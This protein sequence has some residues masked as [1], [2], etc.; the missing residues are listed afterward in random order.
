MTWGK[1]NTHWIKFREVEPLPETGCSMCF[2]TDKLLAGSGDATYILQHHS[3]DFKCGCQLYPARVR[4]THHDLCVTCETHKAMME[5]VLKLY[6]EFSQRMV[7]SRAYARPYPAYGVE[8]SRSREGV[9]TIT[10]LDSKCQGKKSYE[11][12]L[13]KPPNSD[14]SPRETTID[15]SW[16][17]LSSATAWKDKCVHRQGVNCRESDRAAVVAPDWLIDTQQNCMVRGNLSMEYVALSYRWGSSVWPRVSLDKIIE[18]Q[19]PGSLSDSPI[20]QLPI[21][22][23][24]IHVVKNIKERYLWVDAACIIH[25]DRDHLLHQ[26]QDMGAI[27]ASAKL[28]IISTDGDAMAGLPGLQH[29]SPPRKLEGIFPWTDNREIFVRDLPST[30]CIFV[31]EYYKRGWTLQEYVL[32]HRRL[33]FGR[34]QIHWTCNCGTWHEDLPKLRSPLDDANE[35][36][37]HSSKILRR[38]PDLSVLGNVLRSYNNLGLTYP[39][40]ALPA[41]AG[42]LKLFSPSFEGGFLFGMPVM[43]FEAA[44]LWGTRFWYYNA[45]GMTYRGLTRRQ[46]SS[47]TPGLMPNAELPSWSWVGWKSD[48][49]SILRDEEDYQVVTYPNQPQEAL[50]RIEKWTTIPTVHWFCQDTP[51]PGGDRERIRSSWSAPY[52]EPLR[53]QLAA[54]GWTREDYPGANGP[55]IAN[56]RSIPFGLSGSHVYSHPEF[57]NR[58]FWRSFPVDAGRG[59]PQMRQ[60]R[61]L[62]CTTQRAFFTCLRKTGCTMEAGAMDYHLELLDDDD[63]VCGWVQLPTADTELPSLSR[64]ASPDMDVDVEDEEEPEASGH[65][66]SPPGSPPAELYE[67]VELVVVCRRLCSESIDRTRGRWLNRR[68]YTLFYGVLC[69]EWIDGVAYRKGFGYVKQ[70]I[71]DHHDFDT[72]DLVLG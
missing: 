53:E 26:I 49:L 13:R 22:R 72:I 3:P 43:C 62:S 70:E 64:A 47:R 42:L 44:L 1:P 38:R 51:E 24:A 21:V 29:C 23:D 58:Q 65:L 2:V 5:H 16:V 15:V 25:D 71:W 8:L 59:A 31:P 55:D 27:Y 40:D 19:E 4:L 57:P 37:I 10:V 28:T 50:S 68:A 67:M 6:D 61:F 39:E 69:I 7:A 63:Q 12:V 60:R 17:D 52:L 45:S 35:S 54:S 56:T 11:F 18:L 9:P 14:A 48:S 33:I 46:H 36:V 66:P 20:T 32:S 30:S 41:I 34:Q